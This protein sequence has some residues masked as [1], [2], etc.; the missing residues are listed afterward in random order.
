MIETSEIVCECEQNESKMETDSDIQ[1]A[2]N[3]ESIIS[4]KQIMRK[5]LA[6]L[7]MFDYLAEKLSNLCYE[8]SWYAKKAG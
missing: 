5:N 2:D 7:A 4:E 8:R 6:N 1:E 3:A